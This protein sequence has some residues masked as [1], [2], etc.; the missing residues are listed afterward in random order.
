MSIIRLRKIFYGISGVLFLLSLGSLAVYGLNLGVDFTG[1]ARLEVTYKGAR[2]SGGEIRSALEQAAIPVV[3][4]IEQG[5]QGYT[6]RTKYLTEEQHQAALTAL[7][8][9]GELEERGFVSTGPTVG[10]QLRR[11]AVLALGIA[12]VAIVLYIAFAFRHVSRPVS[13]WVYGLIAVVALL[14]DV[15]IPTGIFSYLR[16]EID[17]LFITALLT[18]LGFSV[19]DTIVVFDRIRENLRRNAG[20]KFEEIVGKSLRETVTR[21]INT[22]L[23]TVLSLIAVYIFGGAS[24]QNFALTLI[25]GIAIGTYSSIFIASPLLVS[26]ERWRRS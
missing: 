13:S 19:H 24:T 8:T 15:L 14:H 3:D 11:N 4:M 17:S 5:G 1:D 18:V 12:L 21:S 7:R 10:R 23:T 26:I 25:L 16:I 9:K 2:P 20:G 6:I 22:S